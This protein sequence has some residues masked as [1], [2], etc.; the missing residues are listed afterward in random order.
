MLQGT[1]SSRAPA[2]SPVTISTELSRSQSVV[3]TWGVGILNS[4]IFNSLHNRVEFGT[5]LEG[6]RN[7][8]GGG[9]NTPLGTPLVC[10]TQCLKT[11]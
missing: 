3:G 9:V 11:N 1:N 8:G 7:I 4:A 2:R 10:T 6:L 5:I